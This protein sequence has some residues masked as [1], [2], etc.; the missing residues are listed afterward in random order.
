MRTVQD[1]PECILVTDFPLPIQRFTASGWQSD[2]D[3]VRN[4]LYAVLQ[5]RSTHLELR[6]TMGHRL[7]CP[8]EVFRIQMVLCLLHLPEN[9]QSKHFRFEIAG[10]RSH[11]I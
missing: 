9:L 11:P 5:T 4:T 2:T 3:E 10:N 6:Y 7:G 1:L 8:C